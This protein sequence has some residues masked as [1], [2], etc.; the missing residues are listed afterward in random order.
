MSYPKIYKSATGTNL[1]FASEEETGV[2]INN[3]SRNVTTTVAEATDRHNT[4][5]AVAHTAPRA[6]I[7]ISGY[8]KGD[9][10]TQV[11]LILSIANN[12]D[13]Y[14]IS[15]G[16]VIVNSINESSP[17]GDFATV[18]ISATQYEEALSLV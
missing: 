17:K 9:I 8:V 13:R 14:G 12:T 6:E 16:T 3:Y 11:G 4:V 2:V 15:G 1:V 5:Q 7:S 10:A 18:T